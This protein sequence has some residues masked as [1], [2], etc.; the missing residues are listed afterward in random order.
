MRPMVCGIVRSMDV[1]RMGLGNIG[2]EPMGHR[3]H[4]K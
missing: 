2:M 1:G 3:P 4:G